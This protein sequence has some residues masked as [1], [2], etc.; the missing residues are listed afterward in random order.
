MSCFD[1]FLSL[2][3]QKEKPA[4][5]LL[6]KRLSLS[7]QVHETLYF[8][9]PSKTVILELKDR[10]ILHLFLLFVTL[11]NTKQ[12]NNQTKLW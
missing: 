11:P 7:P 12:D 9:F 6:N 10:R 5:E 1:S 4:V 3:F 8:G 2:H